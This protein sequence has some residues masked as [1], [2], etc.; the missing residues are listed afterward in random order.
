MEYYK[1]LT[2]NKGVEVEAYGGWDTFIECGLYWTRKEDHAGLRFHIGVWRWHFQ[3]KI[4]DHRH[5]NYDED[6]WHTT[7]SVEA[8]HHAYLCD[9][10][11]RAR[12]EES[13]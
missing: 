2:K 3:V 7:E 13:E 9:L 10:L 1:R 12:E 4:Y 11:I 8:E 5:W 6:C